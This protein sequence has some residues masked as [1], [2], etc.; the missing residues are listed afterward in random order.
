MSALSKSPMSPLILALDTTDLNRAEYLIEATKDSVDVYKI[1][2]EAFTALGPSVIQLIKNKDKEV[3]I[4]LK[5]HDI[6]NTVAGAVR[7]AATNLGVFMLNLHIAGGRAMMAAAVA[8]LNH[9]EKENNIRRPKLIGV[10][11]LTSLES[12]D[13]KDIGFVESKVEDT[14]LR[15]AK[16]ADASGLDGVVASPQEIKMIREH[17]GPDFLIV[18]PGIR[19]S[20]AQAGDQKRTMSAPQALQYGAD[21][22]VVGRPITTT[23]DP[24]EAAAL[25]LEEANQ[26]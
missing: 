25:I 3:F 23:P 26:R 24:G 10:T 20:S 22:I 19:P 17:L 18:T 14:V 2:N 15:L 8:E 6:P 11:V 12:T 21:F 5:F 9:L 13:L 4:D 1:G 7:A 16:L